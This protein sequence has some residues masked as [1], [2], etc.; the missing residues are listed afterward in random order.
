M[1]GKM[2]SQKTVKNNAVYNVLKAAWAN[3]ETVKM[4]D[5]EEGVMTFDFE[6][7]KD[8]DRVLDMSPWTIH[9]HCLNLKVRQ[10]NRCVSEVEFD[11][12]QIW[13]QVH[14]FSLDML[15]NKNASQLANTI[16]KCLEMG[17]ETKMQKCGYIRIKSEV[18]VEKPLTAGF[19]WTNAKGE[20][21]W[22]TI[23]YETLG[24][25]LWVWEIG[26][27]VTRL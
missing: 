5:L 12:M 23:K 10:I 15:N 2:I 20:E 3:Y 4:T 1:L 26:T 13:V 24:F 17:K 14:G 7:E 8:K 21:K 19:S 25:V 18:G 16:G 9:M 6:N 22:D 27:N 11:K